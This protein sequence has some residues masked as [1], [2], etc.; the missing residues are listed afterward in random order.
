M[1]LDL[2]AYGE[3]NNTFIGLDG[4]SLLT[5]R[6]EA[7]MFRSNEKWP[8]VKCR[9]HYSLWVVNDAFVLTAVSVK[10]DDDNAALTGLV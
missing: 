1:K 7:L 8:G 10:S 9:V 3:L 4:T 6:Q 2:R 5:G